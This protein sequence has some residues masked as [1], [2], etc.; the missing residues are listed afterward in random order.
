MHSTV[1][2]IPPLFV[3]LWATGFIGARYAMP[4][5]EPFGF[6]AAR[7]AI[8]ATIFALLG[9]VLGRAR[10]SSAQA[11]HSVIAGALLHGVY[12]SGV[13]WAIRNGMPAGLTALIIGLQP[14]ITAVLAGWV[15]GEKVE[16]RH[17]TGLV[18]GFLGIAIVLG[19]KI[20]EVAAGITAATF[21]ACLIAAL[22]ISIGT[23]WQKKFVGKADLVAG[24]LWQY[25][26]G[27]V[28]AIPCALALETGSYTLGGELVFA[29]A[30]LVLVLSVG[31]VFLLMVMIRQGEMSKVSSLF[32]L[33]PVV[34]AILAWV[35]FGE[36]LTPVQILGMVIATVGVGMATRR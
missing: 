15:L 18:L 13:F 22:A 2:F 20:G 7:F 28:F 1:R 16:P 35:L 9:L 10:I 36:T 30:W 17:W 4:W 21:I 8:A 3:F 11:V 5:A 14:L 6:L 23:V 33:V 25:V 32:Y 12:L 19:P 24:T 34:T 27:A 29:M 31:A 26:G